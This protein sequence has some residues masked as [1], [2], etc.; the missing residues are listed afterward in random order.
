MRL[1][2]RV[3]T[4]QLPVEI[5]FLIQGI[6]LTDLDLRGV[7]RIIPVGKRVIG[8]QYDRIVGTD[9]PVRSDLDNRVFF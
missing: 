2:Y 6:P 1:V 7:I 8:D 5:P 4:D 3:G 9:P